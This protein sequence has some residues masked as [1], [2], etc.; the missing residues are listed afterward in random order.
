MA[1]L[2]TPRKAKHDGTWQQQ[3]GGLSARPLQNSA[4]FFPRSLTHSLGDESKVFACHGQVRQSDPLLPEDLLCNGPAAI[5]K[6]VSAKTDLAEK[7][8][9]VKTTI[10]PL[11]P[12][13]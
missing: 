4:L 12:L 8:S 7:V 5:N 2:R 1:S 6:H 9:C 11:A 3:Q 10:F 13:P